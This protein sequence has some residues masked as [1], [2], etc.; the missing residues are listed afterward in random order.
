MSAH[1][2]VASY[3]KSILDTCTAPKVVLGLFALLICFLVPLTLFTGLASILLIPVKIIL[4]VIGLNLAACTLLRLKT[5]RRATLVIHLGALVI[6]AGGLISTFGYV[7]TVNI[8]EGTSTDTVYRWDVAQDVPLGFAVQVA[9]INVDFYPVPVRIGVMRN[10]RK[11]ELVETRTG[12]V[13]AVDSYRIR[14]LSFEP[15]GQEVLLAVASPDGTQIG[16]LSTSG[17]KEVP[18]D[19]P[20]DFKLVAFQD[21]VV[22]RMWVDLE[23]RKGNEVITKGTS[24]VNEPLKWEGMQFFLTQVAADDMGRLY[25]GIQISRDPGIRY[26]YAGFIILCLGLL[27]VLKRWMAVGK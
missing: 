8:Y 17:S 15:L 7:A 14:V 16:T 18:P 11:A 22:K 26:V 19:F 10:G 12:N 2:A 13:F 25:A 23:L 27:L 9:G 4:A 5:L 20:L 24:E 6:L 1:Q 21:P 3:L